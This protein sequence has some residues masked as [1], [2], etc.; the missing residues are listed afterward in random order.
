MSLESD[1]NAVLSRNFDE[2]SGRE[3]QVAVLK[4]V[5]NIIQK[6]DG[7]KA[8]IR[9][10]FDLLESQCQLKG[11]R[12]SFLDGVTD[13]AKD[14]RV[15]KVNNLNPVVE[16]TI[17]IA[18]QSVLSTW[19][20][21]M[22]PVPSSVTETRTEP[23]SVD[24]GTQQ[25]AL[26]LPVKIGDQKL[27]TLSFVK[28]CRGSF[29]PKA[30]MNFLSVIALLFAQCAMINRFY[31]S[32]NVEVEHQPQSD[33]N[34]FDRMPIIG[35][36]KAMHKVF[37]L[38]EQVACSETSI[39]VLGESGVGKELIADALHRN[40]SRKDRPFVKI[41]CSAMPETLLESDLFGHEKGAY[42]GA[43]FAK[44]GRLESAHGGTIFLD[45]V[46]DLSLATQVKLLRVLQEQS[47]ERVGGFETIKCDVRIVAATDRQLEELVSEGRFRSDL[48]YRLNVFPIT[49]PPLRERKTDIIPITDFFVEKYR[50]I[51]NKPIR[52]ISTPAIDM[53]SSYHWPGN[54]RELENC[55][56]RAVLLSNE[57]VIRGHHMPPSLQTSGSTSPDDSVGSLQGTLESMEKEL[58]LDSLKE[59]KGN[60]A[61]A[62]RSLGLTERVMG[63]RTK[64][65]EIDPRSY[66]RYKDRG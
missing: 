37:Q 7:F 50:T 25:Y 52:R 18:I 24:R 39:L 62:A 23:F 36:S 40:S 4:K 13:S 16:D 31:P 9:E 17:A 61:K 51:H 27:G 21:K 63:L 11:G 34:S 19:R 60:M 58:I 2:F 57:G 30:E 15:K 46:A 53:L 10:V 54:V 29:D 41:C 3:R 12:I 38:L 48:Y 66:K 5:S 42:P 64:K 55:I 14:I 47:F 33:I 8:M 43:N 6:N 44:K 20:K 59:A 49:V 32:E 26:C 28:V 45:E 56:E 1:K 65:Y 22:V 35:N